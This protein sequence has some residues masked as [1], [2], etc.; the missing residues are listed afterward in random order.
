MAVFANELKMP[1]S[2]YYI[3]RFLLVYNFAQTSLLDL[4]LCG[5]LEVVCIGSIE[6]ERMT[7]GSSDRGM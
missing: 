6:T 3:N 1:V 2:Y 7:C 5:D 4:L